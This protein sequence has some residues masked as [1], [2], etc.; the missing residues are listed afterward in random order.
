MVPGVTREDPLPF[1]ELGDLAEALV[2]IAVDHAIVSHDDGPD[3]VRGALLRVQAIEKELTST[4]REKLR[5]TPGG[6]WGM[7]STVCVAMVNPEAG[8]K[9]LLGWTE[10][11]VSLHVLQNETARLRA[12]GVKT[13]DVAATLA[14]AVAKQQNTTQDRMLQVVHRGKAATT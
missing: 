13:G 9:Q 10:P 14:K 6:L 4:L 7:Y 5:H 1:G 11:L 8:I 12:A 3:A 2:P